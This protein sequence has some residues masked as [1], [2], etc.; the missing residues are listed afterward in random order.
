MKKP[1]N[2][3]MLSRFSRKVG[4]S[5]L[6]GLCLLST[7]KSAVDE[8]IERLPIGIASE[9]VRVHVLAPERAG[10]DRHAPVPRLVY[11]CDMR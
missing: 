1:P 4:G 5:A 6:G 11:V 3:N 8:V 7:R 9:D 10:E 2:P